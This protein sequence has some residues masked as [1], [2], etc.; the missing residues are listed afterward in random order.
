MFAARFL[1]PDPV[2]ARA[3]L[4]VRGRARA[5]VFAY[6]ELGR[7]RGDD[8]LGRVLPGLTRGGPVASSHR[9]ASKTK[10]I[11]VPWGNTGSSARGALG[12]GTWADGD[13]P[14]RDAIPPD[15][16]DEEWQMK[17]LAFHHASRCCRGGGAF[18]L[19]GLAILP[20]SRLSRATTR[21]TS[22]TSTTAS[23]GART[24]QARGN[25][26]LRHPASRH[27][28]RLRPRDRSCRRHG[29]P[30]SDSLRARTG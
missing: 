5:L 28:D 3:A 10:A 8:R 20:R 26:S 27:P 15:A 22:Q 9:A 16:G 17:R 29:R 25:G 23:L 24:L 6:E 4:S 13:P 2:R 30:P 18:T 12:V 7:R 19:T 1:G 11:A 21:P 14:K